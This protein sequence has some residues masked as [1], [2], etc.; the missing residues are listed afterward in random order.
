MQADHR[1]DLT[2]DWALWRDF[3]VRSAGFPVEGLGVF[4]GEGESERLAEVARNPAFREAVAWQSRESLSRAVDKHAT[5]M[6]ES[7]S[8]V[9]RREDVI[10]S[11]WQRYCAKND[12]IGFFGPLAWGRFAEQGDGFAMRAGSPEHERVVHFENW[13]VEA[14]GATAGVAPLVPMDPFPER[15]LRARLQEERPSELASLDRLEAAR[16]AVSATPREGLGAALAELDRVFEEI[17]GR[18]AVRTDGDTGGGRTIAYL[19]CLR[20]LNLTLGG[21]VL[22][23]LSTTLPAVL[24]ASR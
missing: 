8:R 11:Y 10:A 6:Q 20:D 1:V 4:G 2:P 22:D 14:V 24:Y 16:D 5:G 9:R 12:T 3:A 13:A 18:E 23:E 7:P 17:T 19:D 15:A 21:E